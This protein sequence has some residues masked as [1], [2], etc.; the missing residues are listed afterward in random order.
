VTSTGFGIFLAFDSSP[1]VNQQLTLIKKKAPCHF[2]PPYPP[3][4]GL[5]RLL[6]ALVMP[7]LLALRLLFS[8]PGNSL[9]LPPLL[10]KEPA[11]IYDLLRK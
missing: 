8:R 3:P 5:D 6:V 11:E 7:F 4:D 10:L 1:N 2:G 9:L